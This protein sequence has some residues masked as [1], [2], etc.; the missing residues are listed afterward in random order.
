MDVAPNYPLLTPARFVVQGGSSISCLDPSS[1]D[2]EVR[3]AFRSPRIGISDNPRIFGWA[4]AA[5]GD[6]RF[7][8]IF[9]RVAEIS[10]NFKGHFA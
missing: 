7:G 8:R 3:Y 6:M 5:D 1:N 4:W 9:G 10:S 2:K